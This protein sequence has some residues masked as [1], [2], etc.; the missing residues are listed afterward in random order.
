MATDFFLDLS[1]EL[2]EVSEHFTLLLHREDPFLTRVVIDEGD[3]VAASA[4]RGI[5]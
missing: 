3:V 1:H 4:A 2:L 5:V